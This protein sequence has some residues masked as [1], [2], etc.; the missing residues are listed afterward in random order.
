MEE[1]GGDTTSKD[2]NKDISTN[3]VD[4]KIVITVIL[5]TVIGVL[6]IVGMVFAGFRIAENLNSEPPAP[7]RPVAEEPDEPVLERI[8]V[9]YDTVI[10]Q[11]GVSSDST[12]TYKNSLMHRY[13]VDDAEYT[14]IRSASELDDFVN[15]VN[16]T[17][18]VANGA[19]PFTYAVND[20]FF[21][22]GSII[23]A[24][25]E[26]AGLGNVSIVD[27]YRDENYNLQVYAN[28]Q[29]PYDTTAVSGKFAL[30]EVQNIQPKTVELLW[31]EHYSGGIDP[32]E[33]TEKKPIVYLYPTKTT[34]VKVELSNPE[35]IAVDYPDY[36][37]GWMVTAQP[38]G[39]L[40]TTDGKKLYALYYESQNIK[41]YSN[42]KLSEGFVVPKKNIET[43]LD[44]KLTT[45]GLNFKEREEFITYWASELE[46][47]PYAYIRF[48]TAAE[49]ERNMGL[50][51]TPRPDTTI[52]IMMEY[53][54]LQHKINVKEQKL[55]QVE[56]K[57]FTVVEWGG[58]EIKK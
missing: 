48:Q 26:D 41:D 4:K 12:S 6:V 19:T 8:K 17:L 54:K 53:K 44:Q 22:T 16:G 27:V 31:N 15:T 9:E 33:P 29:S 11:Y 51:V 21:E 47:S 52:R 5:G 34:K 10:S 38:N 28:Y 40:T 32:Y 24:A 35:R 36:R 56:R 42:L 57:G 49:I 55:Q 2:D 23:A 37:N 3:Y 30:I 46:E 39:T 45:L 43:F 25:V 18:D 1:K 13:G 20:K 50:K 14:I 7:E 58:T